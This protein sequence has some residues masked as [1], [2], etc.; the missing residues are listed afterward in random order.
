[1]RGEQVSLIMMDRVENSGDNK[2]DQS[3]LMAQAFSMRK[4]IRTVDYHDVPPKFQREW[5]AIVPSA[6]TLNEL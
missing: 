6:Y 4:L 5:H 1:M 3:K 2:N